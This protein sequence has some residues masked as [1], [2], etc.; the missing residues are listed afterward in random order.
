MAVLQGFRRFA[1]VVSA[2]LALMAGGAEAADDRAAPLTLYLVETA[3]CP[4]CILWDREVGPGYSALAGRGEA[5]QL[6]RVPYHAPW[7]APLKAAESPVTITP[8]FVLMRGETEI[9][10]IEGYPGADFFWP[11]LDDLIASEPSG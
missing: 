3:G 4:Y 2:A 9:G 11:L 7:P 8:T 6:E 10:R 1:M 5:P